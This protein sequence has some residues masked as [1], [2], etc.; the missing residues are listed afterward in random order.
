MIWLLFACNQP[1]S[2]PVKRTPVYIQSGTPKAGV[3]EMPIDFP[4]GSPMGGYSSRCNYLGGAGDVDKRQSAYTVAFNS[5]AGIQTPA[6]A[7]VMWLENGD[8]HFVIYKADVIYSYDNLVEEMEDRLGTATGLDLDGKVMITTSHTHNAPA[9]FSDQIHFYLGGDRYNEEI[10]QRFATSLETIGLEAYNNRKD[11]AI[12]FS[13][14][15]D[16]DPDNLVYRDRRENNDELAIWDDVPPGYGKDPYLWILRVDDAD[17]TPMGMLFHFG[18]HGTSLNDD[19]AMI[20]TD[21]TGHIEY[22]L[23]QQFDHPIMVSHIQGSGGDVSPAGTSAHGHEYARMEGIGEYAVDAIYDLWERTPVS[24]EPFTMETVS[25]SAPQSQEEIVVTRNDTVDWRYIPFEQ[26]YVPDDIIFDENGEIISPLDE[27]NAKYGAVFCGYDDP[28]ISTV[29]IG[30]TVYPYDGCMQVDLISYVINGVFELSEF[31]EGGEAPLPLP[32]SSDA[33]FST[34]RLG[35]VSILTADEEVVSEDVLFGFFPGE[36]TGMWGEQFRRRVQAELGYEFTIPVGYAQDHEGYLLI[37]EDWLQGGYEA[38]INLWGPL[39]GEYIM[40]KALEASVNFSTDL[41]EP[42]DPQNQ[43]QPTSYPVRELPSEIPDIT[44]TAGTPMSSFPEDFWIPLEIEPQLQP[45]IEIRRAQDLVQFSFEGGDPGVDT[46]RVILEVEQDG[47]WIEV[48]DPSGRPVSEQ[49][50]DILLAY[51]PTPL[52]PYYN[53]QSHYWWVAWQAIGDRFDRMGLPTGNYRFHIYGKSFTGNATQWPW[54][55][56]DYE[57]TSPSFSIVPA[58]LHIQE[59][60]QGLSVSLVGPEWGYRLIDVNGSS[61]GDNPPMSPTLSWIM[62]DGTETE[63]AA[64]AT[65][66]NSKMIFD[67]TPPENAIGVR[68]TDIYN[69]TGSLTWDATE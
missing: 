48:L 56:E 16:W 37:P 69:N 45:D 60:E 57:L 10:F 14:A 59:E 28:L 51:T 5:S 39:Q 4:V 27:F 11:A 30:A 19:N 26:D 67:V 62:D 58:D 24:T 31:W 42:Q 32:S 3:S 64:V 13:Y 61:K 22:I 46:P 7:K 47:E 21:S 1:T 25:R 20:S 8:Q 55:T 52:Y 36:T 41:L 12:G 63:D 6:M 2:E 54:P 38:N 23:Q 68:V 66:Q 53:E 17:G 29:T 33:A 9:N 44:P 35:P 34:T 18:I 65:L 50:P 49:M 43:W 15:K 40:E